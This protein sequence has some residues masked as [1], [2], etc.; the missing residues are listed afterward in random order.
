MLGSGK[1][2]PS[3]SAV[4][5]VSGR[6]LEHQSFWVGR[7]PA[8]LHGACRDPLLPRFSTFPQLKSTRGEVLVAILK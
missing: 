8:V 1:R 5:L 4:P 2:E 6:A 3:A 7:R